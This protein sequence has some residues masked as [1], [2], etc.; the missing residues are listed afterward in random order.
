MSVAK[1]DIFKCQHCA[2]M[3]EVLQGGAHPVCCGEPMRHMP[4]Q[5][6][7]EVREKHVPVVEKLDEG[8]ILVKVG[9]IP[10][11]MTDKH[12]IEWIEVIFDNRVYRCDLSPT[13]K[14]EA[15][16]AISYAPGLKVREYCNIHGLWEMVTE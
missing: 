16:F 15:E 14:P 13:D 3:V 1:M 7:D 2:L 12:S 11:P 4:P 8:R 6:N 9:S 5:T 10:H